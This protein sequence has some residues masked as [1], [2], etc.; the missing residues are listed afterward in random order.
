MRLTHVLLLSAAFLLGACQNSDKASSEA[1]PGTADISLRA[2]SDIRTPAPIA[3]ATFVPNSVASWLGH[4]ILLD[5]RGSLHR[6]TTDSAETEIAALGKYAD[7]LG[8][9]REK[10]A[11]V[12]L[13]LTP[14]GQIKAF[15][16]SD[17]EGNFSPLAV[18]QPG[19][20]YERF[21][22]IDMNDGATIWTQSGD[23]S[24]KRLIPAR[25]NRDL[26]WGMIN[27]LALRIRQ[28]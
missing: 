2:T 3:K 15:I 22:A 11:G 23:T 21:C 12:F 24:H 5:S 19:T 4:I 17:D 9:S 1:P 16:E 25:P 13:A 18:S 28:G 10:K 8:L 7:V 27:E 26:T 6:A 20:A 14:Q